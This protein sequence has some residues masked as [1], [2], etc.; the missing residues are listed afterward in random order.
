MAVV[1]AAAAVLFSYS[2]CPFVNVYSIR[3][4]QNNNK[5][6]W[7]GG[8]AVFDISPFSCMLVGVHQCAPV[9]SAR[10]I[11]LRVYY[12]AALFVCCTCSLLSQS[13]RLFS[14]IVWMGYERL[15]PDQINQDDDF[16]SLF[17][18]LLLH[19]VWN[20]LIIYDGWYEYTKENESTD[21]KSFAFLFFF[22]FF[23]YTNW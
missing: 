9:Y 6:S 15:Q 10:S 23:F 12:I 11:Q 18:F 3:F 4:A 20:I 17:L 22:L 16:F 21:S 7:R 19:L 14:T 8:R 5:F 1:L 2:G 13:E